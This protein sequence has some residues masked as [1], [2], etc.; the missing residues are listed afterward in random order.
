[1]ILRRNLSLTGKSSSDSHSDL[2]DSSLTG[3]CSC[4]ICGELRMLIS[5]PS[6]T[7]SMEKW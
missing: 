1:V 3:V 7:K 5:A 2:R 4:G 6:R